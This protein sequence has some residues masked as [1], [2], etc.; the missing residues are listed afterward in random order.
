MDARKLS[1]RELFYYLRVFDSESGK[2]VGHVVDITTDGV[3]LI[4][5]EP[6]VNGEEYSL[7]AS[8]P[9]SDDAYSDL[10]FKAEVM[11]CDKDVNP[12][13]YVG[14]LKFTDIDE[15]DK[16]RVRYLINQYGFQS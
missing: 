4:R 16:N 15:V 11:W 10:H 12:E 9:E 3:K 5:S 7:Y 1:R 14:G 6:F 8:L 13:F 2:V